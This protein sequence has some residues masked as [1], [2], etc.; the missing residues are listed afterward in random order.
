MLL[1]ITISFHS[2]HPQNA[3]EFR[4]KAEKKLEELTQAEA[5]TQEGNSEEHELR[6]RVQELSDEANSQ[7]DLKRDAEVDYKKA[8]EPV[9]ALERQLKTLGSE[10]SS[11]ERTLQQAKKRLEQKRQE[12]MAR[13][14]SKESDAAQRIQRLQ[15]AEETFAQLKTEYDQ[16]KQEVTDSLR[17][18]EELEPNV[19]QAKANVQDMERR[20]HAIDSKIRS[21]ESGSGD[22]LAVF[23]QRVPQLK[24][25]VE[26]HKRQFHGP[27]KGP[28][29]S[30]L[31][32]A[33]GK[34]AF[35]KLAELG[36]GSGV[37]DRFIVTNDHDRKVLQNL[38]HQV[39]C[40]S[41]CG[42]YQVSPSNGRHAIPG[43]PVDGIETIA[44]TFNISDDLV[45]NC[46]VDNCKIE[47][48]ALSRSKQE[49]E[50]KLLYQ[51]GGRNRIRG[52]IKSVY[53]L[54]K[55][56]HWEVNK[57]G[58]VSMMSN[59]K[60][61]RQTV[62]LDK[63]A[64][65]VE[66]RREADQVQSELRVLNQEHN[67]LEHQH[68]DRQRAWN[69][70]KKHLTTLGT[71]LNKAA[72][73]I[74]SIKAEEDTAENFDTDTSDLEEDITKA[75]TDLDDIQ[76]H[77]GEVQMKISV[78]APEVDEARARVEQLSSR[79]QKIQQELAEASNKLTTYMAG[80][81]QRE[82]KLKKK[83]EKVD[84]YKA[85]IEKQEGKVATI[86]A[87]CKEYL[88][89]ARTLAYDRIKSKELQERQDR[90]EQIGHEEFE[91]SQPTD[92]E[93]EIIEIVEA[94]NAT[95][96]YRAKIDRLKKKIEDE[97]R[98]RNADKEDEVVAREKYERAKRIYEGKKEQLDEIASLKVKLCKDVAQRRERWK[99]FRGHIART[100]SIK[101][102]EILN[103]KGSSGTVDYDHEDQTLNLIVQ[104]DSAD[105]NSQQSDVKALSGGER[106]FTTIALL[107]ALGESIET[108]FRIMDEFDV[109]MDP[110]ARK[111]TIQ[112]LIET[113]KTFHNR[114]FIFITP[115]DVSSVNTD[116]MVKIL[117]MTPPSR[118]NVAGGPSQQTLDFS[119]SQA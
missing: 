63:T 5:A 18:Y 73:K 14:G 13:E 29:G 57:S 51:Q 118:N 101:F 55:G 117:K 75:Q 112:Q 108:P 33:P 45:F 68:T 97:K 67:R 26:K 31:K 85:I 24:T 72:E 74:D 15:E 92:A 54:P 111:L 66:A 77:L 46:L 30:F 76:E 80:Q 28:I 44:T 91:I 10:K 53:F 94:N 16:T 115:Q 116:P 109:F 20:R 88:K 103:L 114:Q 38:R 64:A 104:K 32:I 47:E 23:G 61:L 87:D 43:P 21:L 119:Q 95:E 107:M 41:D 70:A 96:W 65:L 86:D 48:R 37:L 62:D 8:R 58:S 2:I 93:L 89:H 81:T 17:A 11:A 102:D 56:D 49:S 83:R 52:N 36:M 27:V 100:T 34:E 69:K 79:T 42:I 7:A 19:L 78:K 4:A 3:R 82:E 22:S 90:G 50:E 98:L 6:T 60:E 106:S 12:I 59:E 113:A 25:L 1:Q 84:Q 99:S 110:V 35:G 40:H 71:D 39:G 105:A 9:K